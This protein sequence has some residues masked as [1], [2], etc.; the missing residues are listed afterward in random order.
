MLGV[1]DG[2]PNQPD[3]LVLRVDLHDAL[4]DGQ[5]IGLTPREFEVLAALV[6]MP[7]EVVPT[8]AL[9]RAL[10]GSSDNADPH[11]IEVYVSR[12]RHKLSNGN[13]HGHV[14]RTVRSRGYMYTPES[15]P[16]PTLRMY[17]DKQLILREIQPDDRPFFGWQPHDVI[18]TFFVLSTNSIVHT[19]VNMALSIVRMM[20]LIDYLN[21]RGSFHV[22]GADG[23]IHDVHGWVRLESKNRMFQ[24]MESHIYL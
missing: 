7:H 5:P 9:L 11:A 4:V 16:R 8:D 20:C 18:D 13:G 14:I 3:G 21:I 10:W 19:N 24:G 2:Y 12:I 15:S 22:R 1:Q 17:Y 6:D 23:A